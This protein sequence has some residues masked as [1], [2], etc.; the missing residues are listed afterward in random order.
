[1]NKA[2]FV[3]RIAELVKEKKID[4]ISALRDESD[5]QGMRVVIEV[6]RGE[7]TDV[8]LNNLFVHTQLQS[9]FGINMV[10]LQEGQPKTLNLK[11]LIEAFITHRREVVTRRTVFDLGKARER[12]HILE[13]L[14]VALANIDAMIA[15]IKKAK[16]SSEAKSQLMKQAWQA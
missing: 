10:A 6:R 12:V 7:N 15:L 13:G 3:E 16:D 9:V 2:R 4:G 14:A 1:V 11:E 5:K 8:I